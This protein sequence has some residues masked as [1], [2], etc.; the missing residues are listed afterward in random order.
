M[1]RMPFHLRIRFG[2]ISLP[3]VDFPNFCGAFSIAAAE[4]I[5]NLIRCFVERLLALPAKQFLAAAHLQLR[6]SG[7]LSDS[8][9]I[10]RACETGDGADVVDRALKD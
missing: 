3:V 8:R 9:E 7:T 10:S 6:R 4:C 5:G 1:L 2:A